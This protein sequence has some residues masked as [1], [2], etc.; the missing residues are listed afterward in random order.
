MHLPDR[1]DGKIIVTN[2]TTPED[3]ELLRTR[4]VRILCTTTPRLEGR[5]FG[6]NVMEAALTAIAGKKR[7][8][9]PAELQAMLSEDDLAPTVLPLNG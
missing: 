2:T 8:L 4:G 7:S 1:L 9:T 5:T 3:V 6:T